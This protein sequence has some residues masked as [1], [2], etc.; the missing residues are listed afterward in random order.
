MLKPFDGGDVP[1]GELLHG[2]QDA[3]ANRIAEIKELFCTRVDDAA[4][5]LHANELRSLEE[6]VT[7]TE[8]QANKLESFIEEEEEQIPKVEA[9]WRAQGK[10]SVHL[11]AIGNNLPQYLP[12]LGPPQQSTPLS[13]DDSFQHQQQ[14]TDVRC[15][16]EL[17]HEEARQATNDQPQSTVGVR[18]K[19]G[20]QSVPVSAPRKYITQAE[21]E[22]V[23]PYMRGRLT[24]DKVNEAVE[25]VAVHAENK[26]KFLASVKSNRRLT[27]EQRNE[28]MEL[29]HKVGK[30]EAVRNHCWFEES[31]LKNG[32]VLKLDKTG[33]AILMLLR[34]LR[35][36]NEVRISLENIKTTV[37]VLM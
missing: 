13:Q 22:S 15:S 30:H 32:N 24:L 29:L 36:L 12:G 19:R 28:G 7:A 33:K 8:A 18:R 3:F 21:L 9:L 26:A 16:T 35:R 25:E 2:I 20:V 4:V 1:T 34:H 17:L 5:R 31:D 10:L 6:L 37:Y 23:S 11:K 14:R 27:V